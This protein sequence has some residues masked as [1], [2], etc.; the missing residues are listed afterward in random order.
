MVK[1]Q[2]YFLRRISS[3]IGDPFLRYF[4]VYRKSLAVKRRPDDGVVYVVEIQQTVRVR[5]ER[6][7]NGS[8]SYE[9][10]VRRALLFDSG[11]R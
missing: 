5:T 7:E 11:R 4:Q 2:H 10:I 8:W 9:S 6:N 3:S 1:S